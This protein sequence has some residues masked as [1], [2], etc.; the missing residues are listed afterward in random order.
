MAP[1]YP[2]TKKESGKTSARKDKR[3]NDKLR[4]DLTRHH[5]RPSLKK[6]VWNALRRV[7]NREK[8]MWVRTKQRKTQADA[9]LSPKKKKERKRN[10]DEQAK[11][12]IKPEWR[13]VGNQHIMLSNLKGRGNFTFIALGSFCILTVA[14]VAG[15]EIKE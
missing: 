2:H 4:L 7:A 13:T 11:R 14:R 5:K 9:E 3:L 8:A 12:K 6:S 10:S 15:G 1:K